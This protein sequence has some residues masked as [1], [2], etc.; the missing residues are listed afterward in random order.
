MQEEPEAKRIKVEE[1]EVEEDPRKQLVYQLAKEFASADDDFEVMI[2]P[3]PTQL[4]AAASGTTMDGADS[5]T[6]LQPATTAPAPA[7]PVA[8]DMPAF[9]FS[10]SSL[11]A[12][13]HLQITPEQEE[14]MKELG[15]NSN[16]YASKIRPP[17]GYTATVRRRSA[18]EDDL[19]EIEHQKWKDPGANQS[20]FFNFGLNEMTWKEYA[21]RQ[22]ALR[23]YRLKQLNEQRHGFNT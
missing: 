9:R 18:L 14:A 22:V 5:E 19:D 12:S 8:K 17:G 20:D 3:D 13:L 6:S 11:T 4:A 16:N 15:V 10:G 2:G 23:L 1:E 21:A 7:A